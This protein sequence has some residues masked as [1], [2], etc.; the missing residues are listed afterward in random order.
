[1]LKDTVW[2]PAKSCIYEVNNILATFLIEEP[3]CPKQL[4]LT[5]ILS[6]HEF[7]SETMKVRV[8]KASEVAKLIARPREGDE[9][10]I[11]FGKVFEE[12]YTF[13]TYLYERNFYPANRTFARK[14]AAELKARNMYSKELVGKAYRMYS[15]LL[16]AGVRGWKPRT[17]F[18][19]YDGVLIAA[20][21]DLED[22]EN[23]YEFKTYPI[24]EYARA[25]CKVF[26]F[27]LGQPIVLV[28]LVEGENGYIDFEK[29][30]V[31]AKGFTPP[32][33]PPTMGELEE[34]CE[35]CGL[36]IDYCTCSEPSFLEEEAEDGED[37]IF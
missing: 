10:G 5:F 33:I 27:V 13:A 32:K 4:L 30:V 31:D 20:Q 15:A 12:C 17:Q 29:E 21:P 14:V 22:E 3:W 1:M 19:E 16:R 18:K 11:V 26:S 6:V 24:D 28:G 7:K 2:S 35:E 36:P 23:Y 37:F 9:T 34:A 8:V 25:Q